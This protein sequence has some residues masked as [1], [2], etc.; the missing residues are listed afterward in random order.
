MNVKVCDTLNI[1]EHGRTIKDYAFKKKK[2]V[3]QRKYENNRNVFS[4]ILCYMARYFLILIIVT[5][6]K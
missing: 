2:H 1:P 4:P 5:K 3:Y 6:Q